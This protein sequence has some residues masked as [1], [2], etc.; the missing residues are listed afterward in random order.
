MGTGRCPVTPRYYRTPKLVYLGAANP[1]PVEPDGD[2]FKH[3][4]LGGVKTGKINTIILMLRLWGNTRCRRFFPL[5][6]GR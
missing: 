5:S 1:H 3:T 2:F 4:P 6:S